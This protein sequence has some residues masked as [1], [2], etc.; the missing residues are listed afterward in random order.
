MAMTAMIVE[1]RRKPF[2]NRP[3][4]AMAPV[5][6]ENSATAMAENVMPLDHRVVPMIS[7]GARDFTKYVE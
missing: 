3:R 2:R 6:G 7:S 5:R 1:K 4:S